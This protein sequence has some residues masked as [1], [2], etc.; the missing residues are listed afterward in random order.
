MGYLFFQFEFLLFHFRDCGLI[1]EGTLRFAFDGIIEIG[2]AALQFV[3]SELHG[4]LKSLLFVL[5]SG[6]RH[7]KC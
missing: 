1:R 5:V 7:N 6:Y 2:V 4:H 3:D